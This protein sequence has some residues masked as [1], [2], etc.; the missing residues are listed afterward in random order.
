MASLN[1]FVVEN[2]DDVTGLDLVAFTYTNLKNTTGR[3]GGDGGVVSFNSSTERDDAGWNRWTGKKDTPYHHTHYR[4]DDD[5]DERI[6]FLLRLCIRLRGGIDFLRSGID[7]GCCAIFDLPFVCS[8]ASICTCDPDVEPTSGVDGPRVDKRGFRYGFVTSLICPAWNI[9]C[10]VR[11]NGLAAAQSAWSYNLVPID[12]D[13]RSSGSD[14]FK[15]FW[16]RSA[17]ISRMAKSEKSTK[18]GRPRGFDEDVALD[19]AM[20]VFWEEGYEGGTLASLTGAMRINRSSM[21]AAF[22]NKEVLFKKAFERYV[23]VH[24]AHIWE[25]F[26]KPTIRECIEHAI[27]KMLIFSRILAIPMV[28]FRCMER[29]LPARKEIQ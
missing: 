18:M 20:R 27:G 10:A 5:Q 28:V 23:R 19:A 29:W 1:L 17:F 22:G 21:F 3:L 7:S 2:R 15:S 25:A 14:S 13:V 4:K 11:T 12:T 9:A 8:F 24:L 16:F 6:G 26:E